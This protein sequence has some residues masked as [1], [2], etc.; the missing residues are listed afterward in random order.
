MSKKQNTYR[1]RINDPTDKVKHHVLFLRKSTIE[2]WPRKRIEALIEKVD[3][4]RT[5]YST[6]DSLLKDLETVRE[7]R[8]KGISK[9]EGS[10][11][12]AELNP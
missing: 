5:N 10:A 12:G 4:I 3:E 8:E 1:E 7:L 9:Q 11:D 6:F 2:R